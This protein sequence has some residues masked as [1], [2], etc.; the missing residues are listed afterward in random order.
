MSDTMQN[1]LIESRKKEVIASLESLK[2]SILAEGYQVEFGKIGHRTT[3]AMIYN[4]DHSVE[5]V[6][7]TYLK[8]MVHYGIVIAY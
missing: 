8:N 2:E 6:G 1:I 5:L 7:Y 4:E 3:Y